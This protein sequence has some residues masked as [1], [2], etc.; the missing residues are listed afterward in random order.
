MSGSSSK[1]SRR[2]SK[3]AA[4]GHRPQI[5]ATY[6]PLGNRQA[7]AI[8]EKIVHPR[9]GTLRAPTYATMIWHRIRHAA[10]IACLGGMARCGGAVGSEGT[11]SGDANSR[12]ASTPGASKTTVPASHR[13]EAAVCPEQRSAGSGPQGSCGTDS[14]PG[15]LSDADCTAGTNGRCLPDWRFPCLASCSYDTCFSDSDCADNQPCQCRDSASS[16]D[17]NVCASGGNCR[18]DTD[19]GPGGYCSP[20]SSSQCL[21]NRP[22][23]GEYFCHTPNDTCLEDS[24]CGSQGNCIYDVVTKR[25]VCVSCQNWF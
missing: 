19:C 4:Q 25:W 3:I 6:V 10:F 20:G 5:C 16:T 11:G 14:P 23:S 24:D 8:F 7:A 22:C 15:C 2:H 18:V 1:R 17:P 12:D 13:A 9:V 21:C